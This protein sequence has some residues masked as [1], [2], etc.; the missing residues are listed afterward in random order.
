MKKNVLKKIASVSL[1]AAMVTA[2]GITSLADD[3][4]FPAPGGAT[5]VATTSD[6]TN[7]MESVK[8]KVYFNK[9]TDANYPAT[10][11]SYSISSGSAVA[12]NA[13]GNNPEIFAGVAGGATITTAAT[14]AWNTVNSA[15]ATDQIQ[16]DFD[17][18]VFTAPGIY[19]YVVTQTALTSEQA[20]IGITAEEDVL[21]TS[22]TPGSLTTTNVTTAIDHYL[23][24]YV[25]KD[26]KV[27]AAVMLKD[28]EIPVLV[29]SDNDG[30][31]DESAYN[32]INKTDGFVN[33]LT[34]YSFKVK[35]MVDG[36][37]S[38]P[39]KQFS[40]TTT[41]NYNDPNGGDA[42]TN[43]SGM[44]FQYKTDED[45]AY[46]EGTIGTAFDT[47]LKHS[48]V[49]EVKLVPATA[50]V[51]VLENI[52]AGEGYIVSIVD[53]TDKTITITANN[54]TGSTPC[55]ADA[56]ATGTVVANASV[57]TIT[58]TNTRN[59]ISPTGVI[60]RYAPYIIM[61][62]AAGVLVVVATKSKRKTEEA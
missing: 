59:E 15:D 60:V 30:V 14:D 48:E 42:N 10:K 36:S 47:A 57:D 23:D 55:K 26:N 45:N 31:F 61:I 53:E 7:G 46:L 9:D 41:V 52:Q 11:F 12:L 1:A 28:I 16:I 43:A 21:D 18:S 17:G 5:S 33:D 13:N 35:K 34:L 19:R 6:D 3:V 2:A 20:D 37:M 40:F 22:T 50:I 51:T 44:K 49:L 54:T 56:T 39:N 25:D 8:F 38:D 27:T 58:F 24:V 29:D 4:E 32:T 62:A